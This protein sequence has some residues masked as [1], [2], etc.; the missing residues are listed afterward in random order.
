MTKDRARQKALQYIEWAILADGKREALSKNWYAT[1]GSFD[2]SEPIKLGHHSQKRHEKMFERRDSF[3]RTQIELENKAKRF[4]EKAGNLL[5]FADTNKGD[6]ERKRERE[7]AEL[8][9]VIA[10][11][12]RV[13][14]FLMNGKV[15]TVVRVFKKSYRVDYG[16][17]ETRT[18]RKDYCEPFKESAEN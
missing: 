5:H 17:S 4:R 16:G 18:Y 12:S 13:T 10:V 1:Y 2:W 8:D 3:F 9:K 14:S 15:G 11:G 6:A 7:R